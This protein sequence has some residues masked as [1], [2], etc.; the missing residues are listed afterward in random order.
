MAD[1]DTTSGTLEWAMAELI[2]NP[3][4]MKILQ[5]ELD[6]VVGE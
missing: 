6:E 3:D 1:S 2:H 5:V 4:K